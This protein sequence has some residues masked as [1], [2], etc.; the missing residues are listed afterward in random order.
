MDPDTHKFTF[1]WDNFSS[2]ATELLLHMRTSNEFADVTL[3]SDDVKQIKAHRSILS[4]CSKVFKSIL[5]THSPDAFPVIYLRG[6][7]YEEMESMV[8]FM[9]SGEVTC[10]ND[11]V[12]ELLLAAKSLDIKELSKDI[13]DLVP[14]KIGKEKKVF[15]ERKEK[16]KESDYADEGMAVN[17]GSTKHEDTTNKFI[18][19]EKLKTEFILNEAELKCIPCDKTFS[20]KIIMK[21]HFKYI[22]EGIKHSCEQCNYKGATPEQVKMHTD[23]KHKGIKHPCNMCDYKASYPHGL[24]RHIKFVHLGEKVEK[25][26]KEESELKQHQCH[27]CVKLFSSISNLNHHVRFVHEGISYDCNACNFKAPTKADFK[28]HIRVKHEGVKF[29]CDQC[30]YQASYQTHLTRH[31]QSVHDGIKFNCNQCNA[32]FTQKC[33]LRTHKK[34]KHEQQKMI[35]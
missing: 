23:A 35:V 18:D 29:T 11:R 14:K 24:K 30:V 22:H 5:E 12:N 33:S 28:V 9:Y 1:F 2:H 8:E 6:I 15:D 7:D 26:K 13:E 20:T 25:V 21:Q 10:N 32:Q 17:N 3:V 31:I 34:M 19:D 16:M 4:A 27:H